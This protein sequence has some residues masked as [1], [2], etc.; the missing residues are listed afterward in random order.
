METLTI[1]SNSPQVCELTFCFRDDAK[2]D[3]YLLD[4][5]EM[6]LQPGESRPLRVW[7][8][9]RTPGFF[10]DAIVCCIKE[11]PE[12]VLFPVTC[13]GCR[14]ELELDK[15][16]LQFD[17]TLLL[18]EDTKTLYIRNHGLVPA[19][20]QLG[21]LETL[22][23][24]FTFSHE[25]GVVE[26]KS[27][28]ALKVQFRAAKQTIVNKKAIRIEVF[29]TQ[30]VLGVIQ[31]ETVYIYAEAYDVALDISFPKGADGGLDF[32]CIRVA[33][34]AK[35]VLSIR[36]K[37]RYEISYKS[38]AG[39]SLFLLSILFF[40]VFFITAETRICLPIN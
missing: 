16:T 21:G 29:D 25:H 18:R 23:D 34:E 31:L 6:A 8:F 39:R 30:H 13:H 7:A 1:K 38:V 9:P 37:G 14:A 40:L 3:T 28:F 19:G 12:P 22:G 24:D 4:P 2:G 35:Q 15:K 11:N 36:N 10:K 26:P 20:W 33:E 27:E 5:P 32:G 17:K